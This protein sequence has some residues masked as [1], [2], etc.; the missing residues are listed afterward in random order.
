[1]DG[2][3]S[4]DAFCKE[5]GIKPDKIHG[6]PSF[7]LEEE[8]DSDSIFRCKGKIYRIARACDGEDLYEISGEE[9]KEFLKQF[10]Q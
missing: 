8:P 4:L 7:Y 3:N 10:H 6:Y 5:Q 1:M 2:W 9:A